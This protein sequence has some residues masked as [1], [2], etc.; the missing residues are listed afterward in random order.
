MRKKLAIQHDRSLF[1][2]TYTL[3]K[4]DLSVEIIKNMDSDFKK[5]AGRITK[6]YYWFRAP[7]ISQ[8]ALM[9]SM[10][11]LCNLEG[12]HQ[13]EVWATVNENQEPLFDASLKLVDDVDAASWAWS[14]TDVWMKWDDAAEKEFKAGLKPQKGLKVYTDKDGNLKVKGNITVSQISDP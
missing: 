8:A 6:N 10:Q 14:Y 4:G 1:G 2:H 12:K 5:N 13:L 9:E 7:K 3:V 11:G